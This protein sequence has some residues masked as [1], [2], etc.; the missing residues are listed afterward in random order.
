MQIFFV[1]LVKSIYIHSELFTS[2]T[3]LID[4]LETEID[5]SKQLEKSIETN[6]K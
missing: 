3:H 2:T 4:L 5:L 1:I 6:K